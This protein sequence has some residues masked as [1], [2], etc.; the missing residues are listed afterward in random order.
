MTMNH[1]FHC[2]KF[3][4]NYNFL[5]SKLTIRGFFMWAKTFFFASSPWKSVN[6]S[7][8][9]RMGRKFWWLPWF[10]QTFLGGVY[11]FFCHFYS[12]S[13]KKKH[14]FWQLT[15]I[16]KCTNLLSSPF[17][18]PLH[19]INL[20]YFSGFWGQ[21]WSTILVRAWFDRRVLEEKTGS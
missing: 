5:A 11:L 9:A 4:M 8:V 1:D 6:V 18:F 17:H 10:S 21:F 7:C 20:S 16:R 3:G 19:P 2:A 15:T 13:S 12:L 14:Y